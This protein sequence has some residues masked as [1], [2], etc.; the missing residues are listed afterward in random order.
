M[1]KLSEPETRGKLSSEKGNLM[2][3]TL[4]SQVSDCVLTVNGRKEGLV[5]SLYFQELRIVHMTIWRA[6][7]GWFMFLSS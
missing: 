1:V 4:V 3:C 6:M 7:I 2:P 5:C